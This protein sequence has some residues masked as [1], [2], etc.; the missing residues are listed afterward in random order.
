[1][2]NSSQRRLDNHLTLHAW[3]NSH[4]GYKTT[5]DL[6]TDIKR[7]DDGGNSDGHTE[8][9]Q[10]LK[11]LP[12][13]KPEINEKLSLYDANIKRHLSAINNTR[14]QPIVLRY[15]QYLSLLYT[16]IVLDWKFNRPAELLRQLNAFVQ[17]RNES[18]APS[19]DMDAD[20]TDAD[21][22]KLAFYMATGAGKTLIMHIN[23]HQYLHYAKETLDH[24]VLITPNEGLS[25]QHLREL[26]N[27]DGV[28]LPWD[29]STSVDRK[30]PKS[31]SCLAEV[32][33][34]AA[35]T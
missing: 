2:P 7:F 22:D 24:I 11:S 5:R 17:Q 34:C 19:D 25:E 18:R 30:A 31:F 6:L 13:I 14:T 16:E 23:Y 20:F 35:K 3:I 32:S 33:A 4:F 28:S 21:L 26:A 8:I 9:C 15:F 27:S 10:F 29:C 12:N 1:M